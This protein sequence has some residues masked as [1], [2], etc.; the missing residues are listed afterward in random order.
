MS[1]DP[2]KR[3]IE[4]VCFGGIDV[5]GLLGG[6]NRGDEPLFDRVGVD[7]VVDVRD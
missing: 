5:G 6:Q 4:E 2:E 7:G 3:F 1:G